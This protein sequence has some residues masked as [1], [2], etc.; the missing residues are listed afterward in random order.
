MEEMLLGEHYLIEF[1]DR[2]TDDDISFIFMEF[3]CHKSRVEYSNVSFISC[4]IDKTD[5]IDSSSTSH[6]DILF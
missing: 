3:A 5:I 6:K 1:Y 2:F 4:R